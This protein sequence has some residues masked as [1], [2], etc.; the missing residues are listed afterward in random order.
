MSQAW[1]YAKWVSAGM[2]QELQ[3][4][5]K[6]DKKEYRIRTLQIQREHD[7]QKKLKKWNVSLTALEI[8]AMLAALET[9]RDWLTATTAKEPYNLTARM[10]ILILD[11]LMSRVGILHKK[12]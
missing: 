8:K 6:T 12:G 3:H 5:Y 11:D 1:Y 2:R 4:L 10:E 9:R 7:E